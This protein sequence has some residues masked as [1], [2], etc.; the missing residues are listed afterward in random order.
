MNYNDLFR[1]L[2]EVKILRLPRHDYTITPMSIVWKDYIEQLMQW[3]TDNEDTSYI[4]DALVLQMEINMLP[5]PTSIEGLTL[6]PSVKC[7]LDDAISVFKNTKNMFDT[8][9]SNTTVSSL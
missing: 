7:K 8:S 5:Y 9:L 2:P 3:D 6:P 1:N 4:Y